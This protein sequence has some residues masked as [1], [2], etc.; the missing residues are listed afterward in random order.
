MTGNE[1]KNCVS[2]VEQK[3]NKAH[4]RERIRALNDGLR[5]TGKGG[6]YMM[7]RGVHGLGPDAVLEI[8]RQ[9]AA[10]DQFNADNDPYGEHDFGSLDVAGEKIFWKID[11]YDMSLAGASP[12]PADPEVTI[13][14]LTIMLAS[15]Y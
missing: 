4:Q 7:T 6:R 12:D 15:E 10:F 11:Y 13:R 2:S 5:R 14:V 1:R 3:T 9:I 8:A